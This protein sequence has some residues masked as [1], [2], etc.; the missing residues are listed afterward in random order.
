MPW[1]PAQ[2]FQSLQKGVVGQDGALREASVALCKHLN[3]IGSGNLLF[4]G[5]SGTGKTTLMKRVEVVLQKAQG[6]AA[7]IVVRINAA[8]L[9]EEDAARTE[10]SIILKNL[11]DKARTVLGA[12][13]T[14]AQLVAA[15]E[16]GIVFIDEIDKIRSELG[17][18]PN[19][20]GIRAQESLL[21]LIE[22][23]RVLFPV[24]GSDGAG[25]MLVQSQRVLFIAGGAFDGLYD[26]VYKRMTVGEDA[27]RL[28]KETIM[29]PWGQ[30]LEREIFNLRDLWKTEDLFEYGISPQ[31]IGRFEG[32]VFLNDLEADALGKI[33]IDMPDSVFQ[34]S[35]NYFRAYG[36]DLQIT[37]KALEILCAKAMEHRRLGARALRQLFKTAIARFEYEP[38]KLP[39]LRPGGEGKLP[40]FVLDD[41]RVLQELGLG[42]N[43]V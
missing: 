38:D 35:R 33:L 39:E 15:V 40:I 20:G 7:P 12:Q 31:F 21:T 3:G 36:V 9:I 26:I 41:Q 19:A 24:E 18:K 27:G 23:D 16:R 11:F 29:T 42:E 4:I 37:P 32:I 25:E 10:S 13:A 8:L 5:S 28:K 14:R 6:E 1:L 17:G 34:Q 22:A 30:I 43:R 2:L